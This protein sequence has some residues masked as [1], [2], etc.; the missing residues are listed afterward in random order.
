MFIA[1]EGID[2]CGKTTVMAEVAKR[3]GDGVFCTKEPHK[4]LDLDFI[5]DTQRTLAYLLD[6]AMH[7]P[8]IEDA[9]KYYK[10]VLCDRY[11]GSTIAYQGN[12]ALTQVTKR[13][14]FP[15]PDLYLWLDVPLETAKRRRYLRGDKAE[16]NLEGVALRYRGLWELEPN[17]DRVDASQRFENVVEDCI[18]LIRGRKNEESTNS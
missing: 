8:L 1:F 12:N 11:H 18:R 3:L 10:Y 6:R 4:P 9:I 7:A 5:N 15:E 17:W 14:Y 13:H 2:G 16:Q